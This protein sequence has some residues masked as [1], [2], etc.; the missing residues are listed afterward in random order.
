MVPISISFW[1]LQ[2]SAGERA[3]KIFRELDTN[4]DGELDEDEFVKGCLDDGDLM[5][6]LNSGGLSKAP[7][8]IDEWWTQQQ[9]HPNT[10]PH[11]ISIFIVKIPAA[12][13][14]PCR[15]LNVFTVHFI[16]IS[17][18][19]HCWVSCSLESLIASVQS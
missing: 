6:L 1:L 14:M 18:F 15:L 2:D 11:N 10:H 4:G 13:A 9:Q 5:R 3:N 17:A 12:D 19:L 16:Q 8:D 7:S